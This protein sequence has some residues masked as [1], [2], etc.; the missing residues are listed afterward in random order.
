MK[1]ALMLSTTLLASA[2]AFN[3]AMADT[4]PSNATKA[5]EAGV[6]T[7]FAVAGAAAGGPVGLIIGGLSG[8]WMAGNIE[9]ADSRDAL[10]VNLVKADHRIDALEKQLAYSRTETAHYAQLALEQLQLEMLFKTK[11][12]TL[13]T[14]GEQRL[15][16][17]AEF[18]K[19]H[20]DIDIRLDGYTDPRG[21]RAENQLLSDA[22]IDAVRNALEAQGIAAERIQTFSH[23]ERDSA[24]SIGDMDAYALER[25]V[26][27]QLSRNDDAAIAQITLQP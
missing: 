25:V 22:R 7:T 3:P 5:K 10:E 11:S 8:V 14:G 1:N 17:L 2:M 15:A 23:G 16:G 26:R 9:K 24:A 27:I 12:N 6:V 13:T 4:T 18:L 21:S 20:A 19:R